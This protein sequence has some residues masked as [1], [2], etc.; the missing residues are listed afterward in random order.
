MTTVVGIDPSLTGCGLAAIKH[1]SVVESPNTPR[2]CVVGES[3]SNADTYS[4][5]AI[6][7]GDQT[8]RIWVALP[9]RIELVV[10]EGYGRPNPKAPGRHAERC[11][12]FYQLVE[13]LA[14]RRIPIAVVSP[15]TL[16][17]WATGN[18]K[19]D[20]ADVLVAMRDLWPTVKLV[21]HN[22][23]DALSIATMGAMHLGWIEPELPCH[24]SPNVV[25][26]KE[27]VRSA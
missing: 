26:P 3:G 10:I 21:N 12:L 18:G 16:K 9:K 22:I 1:P 5:T 4:E 13:Q 24:Y 17:L 19:A 20:K 2:T 14:R 7:I 8:R 6:R 27:L 23:A 25:W 11:A 15:T